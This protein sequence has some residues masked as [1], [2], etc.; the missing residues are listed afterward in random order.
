MKSA[1]HT[2]DERSDDP[3]IHI[4]PS[5]GSDAWSIEPRVTR[6]TETEM[7]AKKTSDVVAAIIPEVR[8]EASGTTTLGAWLVI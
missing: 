8:D 1:E 3:I 4:D 5:E 6:P 7:I 2:T